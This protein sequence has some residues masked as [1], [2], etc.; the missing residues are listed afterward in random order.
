MD[1][2]SVNAMVD[3]VYA[4]AWWGM[5][6]GLSAFLGVSVLCSVRR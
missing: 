3:M 2:A 4:A 1:M 6:G 5:A